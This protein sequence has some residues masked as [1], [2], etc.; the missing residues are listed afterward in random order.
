VSR[1][2][3]SGGF[4]AENEIKI[5]VNCSKKSRQNRGEKRHKIS[6]KKRINKR[7]FRGKIRGEF[8]VNLSRISTRISTRILAQISN[9]NHRQ[10]PA[11]RT[12][13]SFRFSDKIKRFS[14]QK[15]AHLSTV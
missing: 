15:N 4:F 7:K 5:E 14:M 9:K 12:L 3:L 6:Q 10:K 8:G 11:K 13:F 2:V 1:G